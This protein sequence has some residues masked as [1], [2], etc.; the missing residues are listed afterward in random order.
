MG[1]CPVTSEVPKV[2]LGDGVSVPKNIGDCELGWQQDGWDVGVVGSSSIQSELP[3]L[4]QLAKLVHTTRL[5]ATHGVVSV[6]YAADGEHT[7][8]YW[9]QGEALYWVSEYHSS[10]LAFKMLG[11]VATASTKG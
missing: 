7:E 2:K 5:P 4:K 3:F 1:P 9:A 11:S 8:I 10:A 6:T